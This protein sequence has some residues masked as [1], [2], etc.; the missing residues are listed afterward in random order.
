MSA[1]FSF[2]R[3]K[4]HWTVAQG[5]TS[6]RLRAAHEW[7]I[8]VPGM[9]ELNRRNTRKRLTAFIAPSLAEFWRHSFVC[10]AILILPKTHDA[11]CL[12]RGTGTFAAKGRC[13]PPIHAPGSFRPARFKAIDVMRQRVRLRC[14]AGKIAEQLRTARP[15]AL[16]GI[17][18]RRVLR[19]D[20][21]R[22]IAT[23][24]AS[25]SGAGGARAR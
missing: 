14:V 17:G 12:R 1:P 19:D 9:S 2:A 20:R 5:R 22:L 3:G 23:C 8:S 21:L 6:V 7:I 18:M 10:W 11:G 25:G 4:G 16:P 24:C 15:N 13:A